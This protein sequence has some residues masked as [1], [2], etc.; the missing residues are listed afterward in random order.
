M[1]KK[2]LKQT[3]VKDIQ[4]L[5]ATRNGLERPGNQLTQQK[6][7]MG[8]STRGLLPTNKNG[9]IDIIGDLET[10]QWRSERPSR[11]EGWEAWELFQEGDGVIIEDN[12]IKL[13]TL[14]GI[15]KES[16]QPLGGSEPRWFH[17]R[18]DDGRTY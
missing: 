18:G 6:I 13:W 5:A 10:L 16:R 12:S 4:L 7:F 8:R 15:I 9:I 3:K 1:Y 14:S 17:I 2:L 11:Q